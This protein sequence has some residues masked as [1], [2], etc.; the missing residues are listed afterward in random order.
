[1]YNVSQSL[2]FLF[3]FV[4]LFL[5]FLFIENQQTQSRLHIFPRVLH[6]HIDEDFIRS[7]MWTFNIQAKQQQKTSEYYFMPFIMNVGVGIKI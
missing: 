3:L 2:F 7:A 4:V 5:L 1:M 6:L